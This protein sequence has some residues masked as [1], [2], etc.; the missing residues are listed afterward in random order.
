MSPSTFHDVNTLGDD[1]VVAYIGDFLSSDESQRIFTQLRDEIPWEQHV[2]R[3]FGRSHPAPRLSSWH[4][5]PGAIYTYSSLQL[6]PRAWTPLLTDLRQRVSAAANTPF[7]CALL[8]YYRDGQDGMGWHSD[9]EP[10]LGRNPCIASLSLGSARRFILRHKMRSDLPTYEYQLG[11]GDLLIMGGATQ[12]GW[13]HQVPKTR[14]P[15]GPRINITFRYIHL[16][17]GTQ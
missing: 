10:E 13:K 6:N 12:H 3:L 17:E 14:R 8:N 1:A 7:N 16:E 9:D 11:D 4:G 5:D 2:V 15:N